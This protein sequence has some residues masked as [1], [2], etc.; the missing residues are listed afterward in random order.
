MRL[1]VSATAP[2]PVGGFLLS[3]TTVTQNGIMSRFRV[4][5]REAPKHTWNSR[6]FISLSVVGLVIYL[7]ILIETGFHSVVQAGVQWHDDCSL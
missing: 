7:F 4:G 5:N 6:L 2:R 1:Q 3:E